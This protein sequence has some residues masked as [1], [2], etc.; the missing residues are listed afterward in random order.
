MS[1]KAKFRILAF[2]CLCFLLLTPYAIPSVQAADDSAVS[3]S[4]SG[5]ENEP[6]SNVLFRLYRV[7]DTDRQWCEE[8]ADYQIDVD[9]SSDTSISSAAGMLKDYIQ[10]DG[11]DALLESKTNAAGKATFSGM[12]NG[13]YLLVGESCLK[14]GNVYYPVPV[15]FSVPLPL[16]EACI[17]VKYESHPQGSTGGGSGGSPGS[18][19]VPQT[20]RLHVL[21]VWDDD[22]WD[23]RP[24]SVDVQLLRDGSVF[25]TQ[26]LSSQNDW[27]FTWNGLSENYQWTVVEATIP[28]GYT[29]SSETNGETVVL[30]N[31]HEASTEPIEPTDPSDPTSP[32]DAPT[33][34][35]QPNLPQ[36]ETE[37]ITKL[38]QTGLFWWPP[39]LLSAF[40]VCFLIGFLI[41]KK[42]Y[43]LTRYALIS[44]GSIL[45]LFAAAW[46]GAN[47]RE[48]YL[49]E[50]ASQQVLL[51]IKDT[52]ETDSDVLEQTPDYEI[53]PN[54]EMPTI[55]IDGRRYIGTLSIPSLSIE[56]PI[57]KE[58][59]EAA[60][61]IAPCLYQGSIYT[62][63]AIIAGHSY[64][65]HFG[66][67]HN[68]SEGDTVS[69]TDA[70]KNEF[71]Y[72]V[73]SVE[74]IDGID[75]EGLFAG[76]WD[77]SLF[78][79]TADSLHRVVV[80]CRLQ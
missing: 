63:D 65:S 67:I 40:G 23:G 59:N 28:E 5:S 77:L 33:E 56:L 21:K 76:D 37:A 42:E 49:S 62:N 68:L 11:K 72:Q 44:C 75:V 69:F 16:S 34:P 78:T 14:N 31:H 38:P 71:V 45:I 10:R 79:C 24:Q 20:A 52:F 46:T 64:R 80:R 74:I 29:V 6:M 27:R 60:M 57:L 19:S 50:K 1:Y 8:Y 54:A 36:D 7:A 15:L 12:D 26:I 13:V 3:I 66:P 47:I 17:Q 30:N 32:E 51:Q 48:E 41:L 53:A 43:K 9:W 22:G 4:F 70:D 25:D 35:S 61:N 2:I 18:G 58:Y 39:I 55:T 73:L